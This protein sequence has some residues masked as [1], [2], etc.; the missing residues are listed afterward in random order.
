MVRIKKLTEMRERI[1]NLVAENPNF[2]KLLDTY[3]S[4]VSLTRDELAE[5]CRI[6]QDLREP[7]NKMLNER[8]RFVQINQISSAIAT[9][10]K[11]KGTKHIDYL[12]QIMNSLFSSAGHHTSGDS[13]TH[14]IG[15]EKG[16]SEHGGPPAFIRV[17]WYTN[18]P[19]IHKTLGRFDGE[20][21]NLTYDVVRLLEL[22]VDWIK[23]D[24]LEDLFGNLHSGKI[25]MTAPIQAFPYYGFQ[26][27][28]FSNLILPPKHEKEKSYH[29]D[30]EIPYAFALRH[31][32]E[33]LKSAIDYS[34]SILTQKNKL[35]HQS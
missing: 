10:S 2:D 11:E 3:L 27:V 8:V 34:L 12:D 24:N 23:S 18:L 30:E 14:R 4:E 28:T 5:R 25:D 29:G 16:I 13:A 26:G 7:W 17:G 19:Y 1:M 6:K 33:L 9:A 15:Y 22:N 31:E 32:E 21:G 35:I 20:Y